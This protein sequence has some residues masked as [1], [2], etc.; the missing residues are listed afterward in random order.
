M[1]CMKEYEEII[2]EDDLIKIRN[3]ED[4]SKLKCEVCKKWITHWEKLSGKTPKICSNV[5]CNDDKDFDGA[6]VQ[7]VTG[8]DNKAYIIPLCSKCNTSLKDD[9]FVH[10]DTIFVS[11]DPC[12]E[13]ED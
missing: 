11:A 10:E 1:S 7:K 12:E 13:E 6:H 2:M 4:T 3:M 8:N 5:E 9:F